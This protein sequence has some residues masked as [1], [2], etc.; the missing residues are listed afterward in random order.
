M[1]DSIELVTY[2]EV[3]KRFG[4]SVPAIFPIS[5]VELSMGPTACIAR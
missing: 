1:T 4:I 5:H 2:T 3:E